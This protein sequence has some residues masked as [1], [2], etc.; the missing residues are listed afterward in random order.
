MAKNSRSQWIAKNSTAFTECGVDCIGR[1]FGGLSDKRNLP[2]W[3][4]F[5][6]Q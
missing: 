3:K 4:G 2:S 5:I 1:Y 6:R